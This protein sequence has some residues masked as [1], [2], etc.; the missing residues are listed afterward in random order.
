MHFG[1]QVKYLGVYTACTHAIASVDVSMNL[2]MMM[3]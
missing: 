3:K 2:D 1:N